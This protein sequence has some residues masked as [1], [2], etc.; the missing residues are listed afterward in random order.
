MA[1]R[2]VCVGTHGGEVITTSTST[3]TA[4]DQNL[5]GDVP[6]IAVVVAVHNVEAYVAE[7]LD[8]LLAQTWPRWTCVVVDDG[9]TDGTVAALTPYLADA[10]FRLLRQEQAG[11]GA[12]RNTGLRTLDPCVPL[13]AFLDGDDTWEP[14]AL[15]LLAEALLADPDAVGA[16]GLA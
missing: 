4:T 2:R 13:V 11:S 7:T 15:T 12:A 10:R 5:P 3:T 9:S 8:S 1:A 6:E 16:Y 14:D